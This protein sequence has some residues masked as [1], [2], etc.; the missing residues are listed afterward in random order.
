MVE[1]N[2]CH[3][4]LWGQ[5]VVRSFEFYIF[6]IIQFLWTFHLHSINLKIKL[7]Y[8]LTTNEMRIYKSNK[9]EKYCRNP[10]IDDNRIQILWKHQAV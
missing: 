8:I 10:G 1:L 7:K 2:I 4:E 5:I 9:R 6:V 3:R